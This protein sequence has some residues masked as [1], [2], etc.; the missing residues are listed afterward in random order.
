MRRYLHPLVCVF[1]APLVLA[2]NP[3]PSPWR[4]AAVGAFVA[5]GLAITALVSFAPARERA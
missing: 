2:L 5:S 1:A 3:R 4:A